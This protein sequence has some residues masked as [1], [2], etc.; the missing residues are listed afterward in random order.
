MYEEY[1]KSGILI[2]KKKLLRNQRCEI[3]FIKKII[4]NL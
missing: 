4:K 2:I 3:K 1:K